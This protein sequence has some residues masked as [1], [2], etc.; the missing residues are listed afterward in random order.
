MS[1]L[2]RTKR[3]TGFN[4]YKCT[5]SASTSGAACAHK[6]EQSDKLCE[7]G[8]TVCMSG[9]GEYDFKVAV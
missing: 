7:E 8:S 3:C 2:I 5:D 4:W 6:Q 9:D 1:S